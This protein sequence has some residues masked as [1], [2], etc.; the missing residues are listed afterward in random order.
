MHGEG[1]YSKENN[2]HKKLKKSNMSVLF[3]KNSVNYVKRNFIGARVL[4]C[5]LLGWNKMN[6]KNGNVWKRWNRMWRCDLG[7]TFNLIPR[8]WDIAKMGNNNLWLLNFK[9]SI[10]TAPFNIFSFRFISKNQTKLS[11]TWPSPTALTLKYVND[12]LRVMKAQILLPPFLHFPSSA[13]SNPIL[14]LAESR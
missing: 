6:F 9:F 4:Q 1:N 5:S 8:I 10:V 13:T 7:Q 11:V 2:S 3:W 14:F 12:I